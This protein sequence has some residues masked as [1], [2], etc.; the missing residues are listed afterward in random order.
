MKETIFSPVPNSQ[1]PIN[2]YLEL[3]SS[4]IFSW[5]SSGYIL[6]YRKLIL[7]WLLFLPIFIIIETGSYTLRNNILE[8]TSISVTSCTFVPLIILFRQYL[9]WSYISKRLLSDNI[10]YEESDW[11]DGEIWRK[12]ESWRSRDFLIA[13]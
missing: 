12:P 3:K 5:A 1:R 9:G 4:F 6:L 2:Q 11:H 10:S 8:L 13:T 7:S